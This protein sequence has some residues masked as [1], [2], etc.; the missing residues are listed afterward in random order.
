MIQRHTGSTQPIFVHALMAGHVPPF[1]SFLLA[2]LEHHQIH[3]LHLHPASVIVTTFAYLYE[4]FLGV[5]PSVAFFCNFYSLRMTA[6]NEVT[7]CI[8]FRLS[9]REAAQL[10]TMAVTKKVEDFR[11]SWMFME[12]SHVDELLRLPV[13]QPKTNKKTWGSFRL[14][15]PT[16]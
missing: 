10:I 13:D 6:P 11:R 16:C 14:Q 7:G 5:M 4:V 9:E 1:S 15:G 8:S 12:T 2:I 3:L